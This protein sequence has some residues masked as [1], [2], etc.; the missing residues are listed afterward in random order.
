MTV[1]M[2]FNTNKLF[3]ILLQRLNNP[4]H[5]I[6]HKSLSTSTNNTGLDNFL[7]QRNILLQ[8]RTDYQ[9]AI[10]KFSWPKLGIVD[11]FNWAKSYF[12][13]YLVNK[14]C[15]NRIALKLID[16]DNNN[17]STSWTYQQLN[18]MS[19]SCVKYLQDEKNIKKGDRILVILGN[20]VEQWIITLSAIRA[21]WI[22]L[23]CT[24]ILSQRDIIDRIQRGEV[25]HII[26]DEDNNEILEKLQHVVKDLLSASIKN[27]IPAKSL[28]HSSINQDNSETIQYEESDLFHYFT[29]GTTSLPKCVRHSN[30]SYPVG[31]LSTMY[32][33]GL[34]PG[35]VHLN[36][37]SPGWAK[38]A[39]SSIFAPF[40][41][42]A[43]IIALKYQ[44]FD[45]KSLLDVLSSA[46]V[47]SFCAPPTVWRAL[48]TF[49]LSKW[50]VPQ[51]REVC[52][53]GEPLNPYIIH[54]VEKTWGVQ[55]R[56]FYGLTETTAQ[57]GNTPGQ[58]IINGSMGK[59]LP[60]YVN[61]VYVDS[62]IGTA[63]TTTTT[64]EG[65]IRIR[66]P[67][68]VRGIMIGYK[69]K[70]LTST[71]SEISFGDVARIDS[72]TT[73][74]NLFFIGRTDDVFKSSDYKISPFKLESVLIEHPNVVEAAVIPVMDLKRLEVPKA[75]IILK[76]NVEKNIKTATS[77]FKHVSSLV[78][79]FERIRWIE[80]VDE[81]PKTISG[82]IR[83]VE[84]RKN[85]KELQSSS[86]SSSGGGERIRKRE[87][88]HIDDH[89]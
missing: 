37:S 72:T 38:H 65:E 52:S 7:H 77:I 27:I 29:S 62:G 43:T 46:K 88:F 34:Q 5:T 87:E 80:F 82:K 13:Q 31:S 40:N 76:P 50:S 44:R 78:N 10:T 75:F 56:D 84:L 81:L 32:A 63:T 79:P 68:Q 45:A 70:P 33:L 73:T 89:I 1:K 20:R 64:E 58:P 12:E 86:V 28:I 18:D 59:V 47:T 9:Q 54:V 85:E 69:N 66:N 74:N 17:H 35:D 71:M 51:L 57:I 41:A 48:I 6:Q 16:T 11:Q 61:H 8:Y 14:S 23:P 83:R 4:K 39:W 42:E 24:V 22:L 60:G 3:S 2:I 49:D 30:L 55:I 67:G 15:P 19:K 53:A 25:D 21:G 36:L 26:Y